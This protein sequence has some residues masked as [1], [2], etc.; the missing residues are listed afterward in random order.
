MGVSN[1]TVKRLKNIKGS[2]VSDNFSQC[3]CIIDFDHFDVFDANFSK[4]NLLVK[5]G[6]DIKRDDPVLNR[7]T[8]SFFD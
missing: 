1:L 3:N 8:K 5:E 4:L 6:L 2:T 7:A